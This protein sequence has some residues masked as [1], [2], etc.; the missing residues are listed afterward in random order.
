MNKTPD[1]LYIDL[2]D[3]ELYKKIEEQEMFGGK[4]RKEQFLFAMA[5]GARNNVAVPLKT[6]E[7]FFLTKD[8]RAEDEALINAVALWGED[9]TDIYSDKERLYRIAEEYAHAGIKLLVDKIESVEFGSF[10]KQF[11]KELNEMYE[12]LTLDGKKNAKSIIS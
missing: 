1:R 6:R 9:S 5:L 12:R 11:E 8:L 2:N 3:R 7:G 4:T 10:W